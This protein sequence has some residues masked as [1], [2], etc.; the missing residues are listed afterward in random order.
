M[1][2]VATFDAGAPCVCPCLPGDQ[3]ETLGDRWSVAHA[4]RIV[5]RCENAETQQN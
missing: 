4:K 2:T 5:Y 3:R 1:G